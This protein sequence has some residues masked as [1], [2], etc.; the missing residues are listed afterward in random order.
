MRISAP[1]M[2]FSRD[3]LEKE[4]I[5]VNVFA[6][7]PNDLVE[8]QLDDNSPIKMNHQNMIDPL[9]VPYFDAFKEFDEWKVKPR[10]SS[11]MWTAKLPTDLKVGSHKIKITITDMFG[12]VFIAYR[13]FEVKK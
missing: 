11:H 6:G 2:Q 9:M 3:S 13:I 4:Q 7:N 12:N 1:A 8:F 5:I 10:E